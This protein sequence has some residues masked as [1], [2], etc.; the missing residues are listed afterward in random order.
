MERLSTEQQGNRL[1][2]LAGLGEGSKRSQQKGAAVL[3]KSIASV[4][5][6]ETDAAVWLA[7][8]VGGATAG[9]IAGS[10]AA[11][12]MVGIGIGMA[13]N[14]GIDWAKAAARH[15][16]MYTADV[17]SLKRGVQRLINKA[18]SKKGINREELEELV[19][20]YSSL[21]GKNKRLAGKAGKFIKFLKD[22]GFPVPS[23]VT[24][25]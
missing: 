16:R 15:K 21:T 9:A 2:E 10:V 17:N 1:L 24:I 8:T 13:I 20:M 4:G 14:H 22:R 6:D 5:P 3:A 7:R 23:Y 25:T 11:G 12:A 18:Q 19:H